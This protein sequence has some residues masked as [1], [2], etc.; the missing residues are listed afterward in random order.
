MRDIFADLVCLMIDE[1]S[2]TEATLLYS[3][4]GRLQDI[5]ENN[6]PF[7][8]I[9]VLTYGDLYQLKPVSDGYC[10]QGIEIQDSGGQSFFVSNI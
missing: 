1:V 3:I 6:Q 9:P 10:F 2:M 7:G 5:F 4:H 8:G